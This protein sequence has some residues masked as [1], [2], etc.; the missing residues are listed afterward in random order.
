[1]LV[2][3]QAESR[4]GGW[5]LAEMI[6]GPAY[7]T[8]WRALLF[9]EVDEWYKEHPPTK[10][11]KS[12]GTPSGSPGVVVVDREFKNVDNFID[13]IDVAARAGGANLKEPAAGVA[14]AA[15]AAAA[16]ASTGA[17]ASGGQA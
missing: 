1:M 5:D 7:Y 13:F 10:K 6:W 9:K 2:I 16:A 4:T 17:A 12:Y 15:A 3:C 11:C 8:M 14:L